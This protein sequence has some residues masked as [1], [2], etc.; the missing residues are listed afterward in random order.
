MQDFRNDTT[1]RDYVQSKEGKQALQVVC[2]LFEEQSVI[3]GAGSHCVGRIWST[4]KERPNDRLTGLYEQGT[5]QSFA[6]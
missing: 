2:D 6:C 4:K 5:L 3:L 1:C